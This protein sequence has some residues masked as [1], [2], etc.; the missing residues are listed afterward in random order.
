[1]DAHKESFYPETSFGGF[2]NHDGT[3]LF[4]TRVNALAQPSFIVVDFGCGRGEHADDEVG[5]RRGLRCLKGKVARVIGV[6]INLAGRSNPTVDEFR[7]L[8]PGHSWPIEDR[9]ANLILCDSV[10]E[11]LPEPRHFF[12]EARRVLVPGGFLCIR[13]TNILG[14]VGAASRLVP[15]RLHAAVLSRLQGSRK[16]EDVFPTLYK[17][18]TIRS[19]RRQM[20]NQGFRSVVCGHTSEPSYLS[21]SKLAYAVGVL[22]QRVAPSA[23]GLTIFAF[24]QLVS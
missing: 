3:V 8:E 10:L 7:K 13:T 1:V 19:I 22:H 2:S 17:C 4:Y 14:Y 6:D 9:S 20:T 11:H 24:G 12:L 5:F 15:N 23:L 16:A 21:F 18:N